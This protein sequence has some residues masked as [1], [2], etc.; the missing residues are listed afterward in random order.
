M[1]NPTNITFRPPGGVRH[2]PEADIESIRDL[3]RGYGSA[4]SI[5][6]ELI[7]NAEDARATRL[8][9]IYVPGDATSPHSLLRSPGLLIANNGVFL[10]EDCEAI[11]Q[12]SLGTKG[13]EERAI[14]RFGKGLKSVFAWC[15]AFFIIGRTNMKHGWQEAGVTDFFNPWHCWRHADWD[16]EYRKSSQVVFAST[17]NHLDG[18]YAEEDCW[19]ALWFPLRQ[20]S[21][22]LANGQVGERICEQFPGDDPK[23]YQHLESELHALAPSLVCLR[24]LERVAIVNR[25]GRPSDSLV[26]SFPPKSQ[27]IP[28]PDA[29]PGIVTRIN[30]DLMLQSVEGSEVQYQ[31]CGLAGCLPVETVARLKAAR[32]WPRIVRRTMLEDSGG[33]PVKGEPHFAALITWRSLDERETYGNV[34]VR[35]SVFFPVGIQPLGDSSIKLI[36]IRKQIT[37]NLHGFFFLD[38]ERLRI[39]GL[40]DRF[41]KS[42]STATETCLEWNSI[43]AKQGA[44]AHLPEAVAAF[45]KLESLNDLECGDL[46]HAIRGTWLW[47]AFQEAICQ[48]QSWR[49]RWKSGTQVWSCIS[50]GTSE[51]QIPWTNNSR[52]VLAQIPML[53]PISEEF[54]LVAEKPD[55]SLPGLH[56]GRTYPWPENLVLRLLEGVHL[57]PTGD[58]ATAIWLNTFL[59]QL[60]RNGMLTP[61][62][63]DA[64]F[65]LPLL[66]SINV[67]TNERGRISVQEWE[68]LI[69][70]HQLFAG[71]SESRRWLGMLCNALP[72]WACRIVNSEYPEWFDGEHALQCDP[73]IAAGIV[74]NEDVLG[75]FA[76]RASLVS[77]FPSTFQKET[78]QYLSIRYLMHGNPSH[79]HNGETSLFVPSVQSGEEIWSRLIRQLLR[80]DG[81]IDSWR[82]LSDEWSSVLSAQFQRDLNVSTIDAPGAW[83]EL[84]KGLI[85]LAC[86]EFLRDDWSDD[87]VSALLRGLFHVGKS[88]QDQALSILR[89]LRVHSLRGQSSARVSVADKD[90]RLIDGFVLDTPTFEKSLPQELLPAWHL[91]VSETRIVELV[92]H[93]DLALAV[94]QQVF[95]AIDTDGTMYRA[96]LNWNYV[97]RRCLESDAPGERASLIMEA[98]SRGD[99]SVRGLGQKLKKTR[100]LP[101]SLGDFIAPDSVIHIEGLEED[102]FRLLDP[103]RDGLAGI[104][105]LA[106]WIGQSKGFATL[107]NYLPHL[108]QALEALGLWLEERTEWRLGLSRELQPSQLEQI[109]AQLTDIENLQGASLITKLASTSF[110]GSQDE[111]DRLLAKYILP[112][113]LKPFDYERGGLEVLEALLR[114]LQGRQSRIAFNAYLLQAA[115]DDVLAEILPRL[116]LVNKQG[117]WVSSRSLIW[118]SSNLDTAAQL[119]DE[120]AQILAPLHHGQTNRESLGRENGERPAGFVGHQLTESPDFGIQA[121]KLSKYLRPFRDGN[122]GESL[123]AALVAVLGGHPKFLDLLIELLGTG[124]KQH[125]EDFRAR[126]FGDQSER[127]A[128]DVNSKRFLV[129]IVQGEAAKVTSITGDAISVRFSDDIKTLLV[130]DPSD[131][132]WTHY[133]RSR[134]DTGCHIIR[135]RWIEKPDELLEPVAVFA[136][137]IETILLKVYYNGVSSACPSN[138]KEVLG[139]VDDIGQAEL[140]R[141]QIY[142]L[143]MAEAR[144]KELGVKAV[145]HLQSVLQLFAEARQARV[146]AELLAVRAPIR[147]EQRAAEASRTLSFAKRSLV[148][149]LESAQENAT[150]RALVGAIRRK[151][152]VFQYGVKSVPFELFQNAD[153]AVV[154][155]QEMRNTEDERTQRFILNLDVESGILDIVH[156]GRPINQHSF[157]GFQDGLRRG[158]DQDLQKMLTLNF[159]DKGADGENRQSMVTGRFGLGFKSV[160]FISERPEV[161]SGRLAFEIKGGFFPVALSPAAAEEMRAQT[162]DLSSPGLTCTSIRLRWGSHV[163]AAE[164]VNAIERFAVAAPL[165][166]IFSRSIRTIVVGQKSTKR[167]WAISEEGLS[168]SGLAISVQI[169][170]VQYLRFRCT[171]SSDERPASVLFQIDSGGIAPLPDE[172]TGLWITTPTDERSDLKFAVNG[173]FKPDAGRQRLALNSLDNRRIAKEIANGWEESLVELFDET[174]DNWSR[175]AARLRLHSKARFE[176]WW[177]QLW[178]MMTTVSPVM[179]WDQIRDGGQILSWI[180]WG[181]SVGAMRGLVEKRPSIPTGLPGIYENLVIANEVRFSISRLLSEGINGCFALVSEWKS[182]QESFP[183]RNCVLFDVVVFLRQ[184]G[185]SMEVQEV[186]LERVLR[187]EVGPQQQVDYSAGERLGAVFTKCKSIF[188]PSTGHAAEIQGVMNWMRELEILGKDGLYHSISELVCGRSLAGVIERDESL[189]ADFAPDSAVLS[190]NYSDVA[191]SFFTKAR[192]RLAA[193]API[194][195]NWARVA[196]LDKLPA[197]FTYLASGD[198]GQQLADELGRDWI[199]L[200]KTTAVWRELAA[201]DQSEIERKFLKGHAW[202]APV[203]FGFASTENEVEP[204]TDPVEAFRLVSEW[205]AEE[206]AQWIARYEER[207][208]PPGFPGALPWPDEP[209]WERMLAPSAQAGW[210]LQ[211]IHAA[212][213]PLGFNKIGRDIGFAQFLI[214]EKW[215]DT[216][217]KAP[218]EPQALL[219]VLDEFLE[220]FIQNTQYHFQMR[221]FV[222][223]YAAARNLESLLLSLREAER[224]EVPGAI[225]LALSPRANPALSGTGIDAPPLA[226]LLG[227]GFSH[228]IRELYRLRRL[229]NP[230]GYRY[231]FTPIR[232]VRRLCARIFGIR[233]GQIAAQ[234]SELIFDQLHQWGGQL[235]YDPTFNHCFDLPLQFLAQD[236]AL[237]LRVLNVSFD[238]ESLEDE[239]LD[240]APQEVGEQW[241]Q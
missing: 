91:F 69:E 50:A 200:K 88:R 160:F 84:S 117:Q 239:S 130:G 231:A 173:P 20:G 203:T 217:A 73:T 35:W 164:I 133:Y 206:G 204:V 62:I 105:S 154:E 233:E 86:L 111:R 99:Q 143:D 40:D 103:S 166:S 33:V 174:S 4:P 31:F 28:A 13:T 232:K 1:S 187:N 101:L 214:T 157:P 109:L 124:L 199:S 18:L 25:N 194:L 182:M 81:D 26:L 144:L 212:L 126:L 234:S 90:G 220:G 193:G 39:Y 98:L 32:D 51:L 190:Q 49:P 136:S 151:M 75:T 163:D 205:W 131:L 170:N 52:E 5:L 147:A 150:Q 59:D 116:S 77:A 227:I 11:K 66:E 179:D 139:D 22:A 78:K 225:R 85:D 168:E 153:D 132:W 229:K 44:L 14:G 42:E 237:R 74:L 24:N 123:P 235:G 156:W 12:I 191:L 102:L 72:K 7:Q 114:K 121:E 87:D 83:S 183:P 61:N 54:T 92:E 207:T 106:E 198:L 96:E 185:I 10:P 241:I 213:V 53:G 226:G 21:S 120:Q 46:A 141:S 238:V 216:F 201:E 30:G 189:R 228:L 19:L 129:E 211:F 221:Q 48:S 89:K 80:K 122:I 79:C 113:V 210:L 138:L 158:Y 137:T 104:R 82:L 71:D 172:L 3:V 161:T 128:Q 36:A 97:V 2:A 17:Q 70:T 45:S 196:S 16:D 169:G 197:I 177:R 159:S 112:S 222:A 140:H 29:A 94:Q 181:E 219:I 93:D 6:K 195:A 41:R 149:L 23:F 188:E 47:S 95:Q 27:R 76:D 223:F 171:I 236:E 167:V 209:E 64:V 175:F 135:L 192:E 110:L 142:L 119:C 65:T 224:S 68:T 165:L 146:D 152:E 8:D 38:S 37:I 108:E 155:I 162:R 230:L 184:A 125:P 240:S 208:Y 58:K 55:G 127:L 60:K 186:N 176:T 34:G 178:R 15:E 115:D 67:R 118:P 43:V 134:M 56:S 148:G 215:L 107:R 57:E 202:L 218:V 180:A 100:W 9:V 63:R 145:P